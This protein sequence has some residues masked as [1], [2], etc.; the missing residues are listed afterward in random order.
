MII[1]LQTITKLS[2]PS[3]F[4]RLAKNGKGFMKISAITSCTGHRCSKTKEQK[5]F[6]EQKKMSSFVL[7]RLCPVHEV[8]IKI[9][10]K[11]S[12]LI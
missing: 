4:K 9:R 7:G 11:I 6:T 2:Q 5:L 10:E 3:V 8:F 12:L 1:V